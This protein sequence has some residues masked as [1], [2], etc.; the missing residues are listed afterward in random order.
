[1]NLDII[2]VV[3]GIAASIASIVAA[4]VS[5]CNSKKLDRIIHSEANRTN[6]NNIHI[7]GSDNATATG[8]RNEASTHA[9]HTE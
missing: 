7:E 4:I 9:R 2:S 8:I 5:C 1:M 3:L 6:G